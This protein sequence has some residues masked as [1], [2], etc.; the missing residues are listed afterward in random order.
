M[1]TWLGRWR[2]CDDGLGEAHY[3]S[4]EAG[5]S[6]GSELGCESNG[7]GQR[8]LVGNR[9]ALFRHALALPA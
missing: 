1:Q 5:Q 3:R 7:R 4:A 6:G 8:L 2:P 9:S